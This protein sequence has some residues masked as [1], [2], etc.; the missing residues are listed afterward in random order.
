MIFQLCGLPTGSFDMT[1]PNNVRILLSKQLV[2]FLLNDQNQGEGAAEQVLNLDIHRI[3]RDTPKAIN[4]Q[5]A[6]V[7]KMS[8]LISL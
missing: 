7:Y 2:K 8:Y 3:G 6:S 4:K 5:L 1:F